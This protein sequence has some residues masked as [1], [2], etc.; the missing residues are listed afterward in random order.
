MGDSDQKVEKWEAFLELAQHGG[1]GTDSRRHLLVRDGTHTRL[2][3]ALGFSRE[4]SKGAHGLEPWA[5][6]IVGDG[7][8]A[9]AI[10]GGLASVNADGPGI[11][12]SVLAMLA[13]CC[14][15]T[16]VSCVTNA[17]KSSSRKFAS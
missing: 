10:I 8:S 7:S 11:L 2:A 13:E 15:L 9:D 17:V 12:M 1:E 14:W 3:E 5:Q 6:A 16:D 4:V